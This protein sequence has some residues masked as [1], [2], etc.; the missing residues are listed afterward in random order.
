MTCVSLLDNS[1]MKVEYDISA[2]TGGGAYSSAALR[3]MTTNIYFPK[4]DGVT[5]EQANTLQ[6]IGKY[7]FDDVLLYKAMM[8]MYCFST[9]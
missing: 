8:Y 2:F 9:M 5:F 4:T 3:Q 6:I 7:G 1:Y